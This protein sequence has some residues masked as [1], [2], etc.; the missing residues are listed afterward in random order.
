[1]HAHAIAAC[2]ALIPM[3]CHLFLIF[4]SGTYLEICLTLTSHI[5]T[6]HSHHLAEVP[7]YGTRKDNR[8]EFHIKVCFKFVTCNASLQSEVIVL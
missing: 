6:D 1:M 5:Q 4:L 2:F 3:L 8:I 7:P